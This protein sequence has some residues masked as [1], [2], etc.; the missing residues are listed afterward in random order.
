MPARF[1]TKESDSPLQFSTKCCPGK[2]IMFLIV[3]IVI[4]L[5]LFSHNVSAIICTWS[6]K[7]LHE[8]I[9]SRPPGIYVVE[10]SIGKGLGVFATHDLDVGDIVMRETP[11]LKISPPDYVKGTGYP[12]AAISR[13]VRN[14]FKT[15]SPEEQAEVLSLTFHAT[16]TEEETMDKLGIIFRTNAYNTG[17]KIGLFPKI[18]RINHSCRPNTSYYWSAK[19]N[20]RIVYATRKIK[21]GEEFFV[22]YIPLLLTHE[23]RQKRLNRYGFKC[24]CEACTQ[25]G[26]ALAASDTRRQTI[27]RAFKA[28]EPQLTLAPPESIAATL[29]AQSSAKASE[30]L[31]EL[32]REERLA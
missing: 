31:A 11:I 7:T 8:P 20:K 15:L 16:P 12:M 4:S 17:D 19:L 2:D 5:T 14:E 29:Q 13:L 30:R 18:A 24:S 28:F 10:Q 26:A 9:C 25:K 6:S 23:E 22:S 27:D 3:L 32:V 1:H 21:E